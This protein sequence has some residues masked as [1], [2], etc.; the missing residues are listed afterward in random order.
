MA[1]DEGKLSHSMCA[2]RRSPPSFGDLCS[3]R[4]DVLGAVLCQNFSYAVLEMD[5]CNFKKD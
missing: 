4:G 2:D 3:P 5:F 1:P